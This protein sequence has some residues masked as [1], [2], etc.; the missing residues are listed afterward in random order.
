[1][2]TI[3]NHTSPLPVV[4]LACVDLP[5]LT[6]EE[7]VDIVRRS[8][9]ENVVDEVFGELF[10][11][12]AR[13]V[14]TWCERFT[15]DREQSA[16]LTQEVFLKAYRY[17]HSFRSDARFSTWLYAIAHNHC[18]TSNQKRGTDPVEI[19]D[20]IRDRMQDESAME[21]YTAIERNQ[22]YRLMWELISATLNPLEARVMTLHYAHEV[23]LAAITR[24]LS[25]SNPSGAKA[26][27][28]SA[29]RKLSGAIH[30]QTRKI[31]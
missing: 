3:A 8:F 25:L 27:I 28:V 13:R 2:G 18:R 24:R 23:P 15:G 6:D 10:H 14:R 19:D 20:A 31:A 22:S 5:A 21:P 30:R 11:R 16:D 9:D 1:M 17:L 29:R 7:L 4:G 26:Y 12:Y